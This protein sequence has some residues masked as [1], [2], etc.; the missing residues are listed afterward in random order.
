M[1]FILERII[2]SFIKTGMNKQKL[3]NKIVELQ[4]F[5]EINVNLIELF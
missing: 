2:Y 5:A 3:V 4:F 1:I